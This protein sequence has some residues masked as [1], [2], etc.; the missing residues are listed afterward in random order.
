MNDHRA[1]PR[2]VRDAVRAN[3]ACVRFELTTNDGVRRCARERRRRRRRRAGCS[4][5]PHPPPPTRAAT[6]VATTAIAVSSSAWNAPTCRP[7]GVT[8]R[9]RPVTTQHEPPPPR[10][11]HARRPRHPTRTQSRVAAHRPIDRRSS[12]GDG[13]DGRTDGRTRSTVSY[14]T[15][16]RIQYPMKPHHTPFIPPPGERPNR[17]VRSTR[18]DRPIEST[19]PSNRSIDR[20]T[21]RSNRSIDLAASPCT[22][23]YTVRARTRTYRRARARRTIV[24]SRP[25]PWYRDA[26]IDRSRLVDE[27]VCAP[28]T[29][30]PARPIA[31]RVSIARAFVSSSLD[32][33]SSSRASSSGERATGER[34]W[35]GR[36]TEGR[37]EGRTRAS[38][39]EVERW[40]TTRDDDDDDDDGSKAVRDIAWE[41][42]RAV[43]AR[44]RA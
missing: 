41:G 3:D 21:H 28:V 38:S 33:R 36:R 20:P 6:H 29:I 34:R 31:V 11:P 16:S 5:P 7:R 37:T 25:R 30:H 15:P 22:V 43:D 23:H 4:I 10:R 17:L 32:E 13:Q 40:R 44:A 9:E 14:G 26:A 35:D 1:Y 12:R 24:D 42:R 27:G 2:A 19:D 18:L 39:R 8:F